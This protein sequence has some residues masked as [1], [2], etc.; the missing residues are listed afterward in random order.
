MVRPIQ[1]DWA[2]TRSPEMAAALIMPLVCAVA[3]D[4]S[5]A[6]IRASF[7]VCSGTVVVGL[8][9]QRHRVDAPALVGRHVVAFAIEHVPKVP[10]AVSAPD[11]GP[12]PAE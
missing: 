6:L 7:A 3:P 8:K 11:L 9:G 2:P 4:S 1:S 5:A 12:G 10:V